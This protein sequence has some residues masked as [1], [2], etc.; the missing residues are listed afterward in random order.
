[1]EERRADK[2]RIDRTP[3]CADQ[4]ADGVLGVG[5]QADGH[6]VE[7]QLV[8]HRVEDERGHAWRDFDQPAGTFRREIG[9]AHVILGSAGIGGVILG[10][11]PSLK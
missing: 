7:R 4:A 1:M 8:R 6:V 2:E 9:G 5:E 10:F 3:N 11:E